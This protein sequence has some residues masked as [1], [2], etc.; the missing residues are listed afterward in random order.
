MNIFKFLF[1][2]NTCSHKNALLK[3]DEGYCPDCG[4]YLKKHFYVIRCKHCDIKRVGV[5]N[6]DSIEPVSKYCENCGG[7]EYYVEKLERVNFFDIKY[8]ILKLEEILVP[9]KKEEYS[10]IWVD[11]V[12]E[13]EFGGYLAKKVAP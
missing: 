11:N 13:G 4:A 1:K 2:D 9:E 8:V 6:F 12:S 5:V 3:G 7:R 10:E